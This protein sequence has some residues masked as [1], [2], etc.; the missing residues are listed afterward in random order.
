MG[1]RYNN[2]DEKDL[3][4][5]VVNQSSREHWPLVTTK[6]CLTQSDFL[7]GTRQKTGFFSFH[8]GFVFQSKVF[9]PDL[10]DYLVRGDLDKQTTR[11]G[12]NQ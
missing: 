1:H 7:R 5:I 10:I 9:R 2:K 3:N 12:I 4:L 8:F 11:R 6:K